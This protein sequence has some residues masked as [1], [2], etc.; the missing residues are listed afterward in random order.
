MGETEFIV[1]SHPPMHPL[2]TQYTVRAPTSKGPPE[3]PGYLA[4]HVGPQGSE[5]VVPPRLGPVKGGTFTLKYL[6]LSCLIVAVYSNMWYPCSL[7]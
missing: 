5:Q 2:Y 4:H 1:I 7:D 3:A 6:V